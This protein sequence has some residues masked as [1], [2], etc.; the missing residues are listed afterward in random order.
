MSVNPLLTQ[1]LACARVM[2]M[3]KVHHYAPLTVC[4]REKAKRLIV[5]VTKRTSK[6]LELIYQTSF[7]SI[8]WIPR[9][10][11]HHNV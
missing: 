7:Y 8:S 6:I 11:T 9:K 1:G 10:R 2:I 5:Q 4:N 3:P